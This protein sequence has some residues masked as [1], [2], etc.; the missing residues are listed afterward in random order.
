MAIRPSLDPLQVMGVLCEPTVPVPQML[1]QVYKKP[2]FG[3][4]NRIAV[5]WFPGSTQASQKYSP[6][7]SHAYALHAHSVCLFPGTRDQRTR[8]RPIIPL[9]QPWNK[10]QNDSKEPDYDELTEGL[11]SRYLGWPQA[12]QS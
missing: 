3:M 7:P 2:N 8:S 1:F 6:A 12:L 9:N 11:E 5:F 10:F 4:G